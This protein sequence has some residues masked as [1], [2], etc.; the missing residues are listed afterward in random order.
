MIEFVDVSKFYK[1]RCVFKDINFYVKEGQLVQVSG[2]FACG[3]TTLLKLICRLEKPTSGDVKIFGEPLNR[4]KY[5]R[6]MHLRRH[7]GVVFDDF[8]LIENLSVKAYLY[9]VTKLLKRKQYLEEAIDFFSLQNLLDTKIFNLSLSEKYRLALARILA[10]RTPLVL[11]DEPFSYYKNKQELIN[12][13][14]TLNENYKMTIIFTS[15]AP[16]ESI[17]HLDI[18]NSCNVGEQ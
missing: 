10:L 5:S 15:Y 1:D 6:L 9:L 18:F 16:I 7:M 8:G 12:M 17:D 4:I 11:L 13:L 3:K 2:G 14:K